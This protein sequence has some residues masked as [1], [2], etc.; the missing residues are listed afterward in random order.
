MN[1]KQKFV[2]F[3]KYDLYPYLL[4]GE[5]DLKFPPKL[6]K[7]RL[8]YYVPTYQSYM[9]PVFILEGK[10]GD[11]LCNYLERL[12]QDKR[13][14]IKR[15]DEEYKEHLKRVLKENRVDYDN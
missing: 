12:R 7:N 13:N 4:W 9:A 8:T 10:D 6:W 1:R 15:I 2:A 14:A 11:V 3:W 5:I